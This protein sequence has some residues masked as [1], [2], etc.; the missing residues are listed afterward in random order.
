MSEGTMDDPGT[1]E[2]APTLVG[3]ISYSGPLLHG[4]FNHERAQKVLEMYGVEVT[5]YNKGNQ[6]F[7]VRVSEAA[8]RMLDPM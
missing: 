6:E 3:T 8:M 4:E 5:S 2:T 7:R 1:F